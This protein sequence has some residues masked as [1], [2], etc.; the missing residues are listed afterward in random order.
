M[1][2]VST[3]LRSEVA[4]HAQGRCE[5]C[6]IHEDDSG[7]RHEVDRIVSRKRILDLAYSCAVCNSLPRAESYMTNC[8][9]RVPG[10]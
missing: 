6:L 2:G 7:F 3:L 10:Y 4:E 9:F 1:S 8:E 5:Y